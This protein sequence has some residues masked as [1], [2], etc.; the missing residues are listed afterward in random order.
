MGDLEAGGALSCARHTGGT[1]RVSGQ[2]G[3]R[4]VQAEPGG[5]DGQLRGVRGC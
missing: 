5:Q 3:A 1:G 4:G 2:A